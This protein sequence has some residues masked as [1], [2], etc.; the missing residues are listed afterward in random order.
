MDFVISK[1]SLLKE[2]QSMQGVVE[3]KS[4][5]PILSN[6][7]L[8]VKKGRLELLATDLEVGIRTSCEVQ[9]T[10]DASATLS[11]RRLF[12][13]VRLLP[14]AEIRF[15]GDEGKWMAITCQKA[16]FRVVGLPREDFP[17]M[18]EFDFSKGIAIERD[19]ILDLINK[20][21][22]AITTDEGRYQ[23]SGALTILHKRDVTMV[24]TDG[25]RLAMARGRLEK[26]AAESKVEMI[27]PRKVLMELTRIG[28]GE[29]EIQ[30]G[31]KENQA[32]FKIGKTI[33]SANLLSG[34][35]PD[36]EQVLPEGNDKLIKIDSAPFS[37]VIRRVA[38]LAGERSRAIKL[39]VSKGT[40]E[41][42]SNNPEVGEASETVDVEYNGP[43]MEVGFNSKYL[44]DFFQAYGPGQVILA[45]KDETTQGL[46][47]PVGLEGGKDYRYVVMPMRIS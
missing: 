39:A 26:A 27:L 17:E 6:I 40:L 38:L 46:L 12:D 5:I 11:A 28:E 43:E 31:Q 29:T 44:L 47:R 8:D 1:E 45:L 35:F 4:T 2:L 16:R 9:A 25:H 42:S 14:D 7:V 3:K 33:L 37:D 21:G 30:F 36:Y 34:R 20:V 18:R 23:L 32:F 19:L 15:K 13:I 41:V 24:A 22:F 10:S